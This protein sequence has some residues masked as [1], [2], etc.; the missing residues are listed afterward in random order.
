MLRFVTTIYFVNTVYFHVLWTSILWV[1]R[2][3]RVFSVVFCINTKIH[4]KMNNMPFIA[5]V[6]TPYTHLYLKWAWECVDISTL[7]AYDS[8]FYVNIE[9]CS[10]HREHV[11]IIIA[12]MLYVN[13]YFIFCW[14]DIH[15]SLQQNCVSFSI[16]VRHVAICCY[17]Y[18]FIVLKHGNACSR[19]C[20]FLFVVFYRIVFWIHQMSNIIL[21]FLL[22]KRETCKTKRNNFY[23]RHS[24]ACKLLF[25]R[26]FSF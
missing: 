9:M 10:A 25:Y 14:L 24:S 18:Y 23:Q 20:V 16:W 21:V 7:A 13:V 12:R 5:I 11:L 17:Y 4:T 2:N 15:R 1:F 19:F 22:T 6:L 8:I 3:D 26:S